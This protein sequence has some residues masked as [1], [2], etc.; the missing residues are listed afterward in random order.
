MSR[1]CRILYVHGMGGGGDSRIP[2]ILREHLDAD[3][4]EYVRRSSRPDAAQVAFDVVC[5]TYDFDPVVAQAQ[6]SARAAGIRPDLV[7]G[8]SMGAIHA[9]ALRGCPH[10]FVSPSLNAPLFFQ[11][12]S[13]LVRVPGMTR[14]FNRHYRPREGDRQQLDFTPEKL[15]KWASVRASALENTTLRGSPDYFH[16]FFGT[17]DHYRRSGVVLIRSWRR[18]F[19][20]GTWTLYRGSHFMEEEYVRN[21]L[22]PKIFSVLGLLPSS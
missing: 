12:M 3:F 15:A 21:L 6:L 4:R 16:A 9:V 8:E 20:P 19:G 22:I 7:I 11:V 18:Y 14:F 1:V 5:R 13:R 2:S 10:L 17:R